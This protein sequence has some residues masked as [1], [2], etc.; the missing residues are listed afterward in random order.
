MIRTGSHYRLAGGP[1][2]EGRVWCH[3]LRYQADSWQPREAGGAG[4]VGSG[5]MCPSALPRMRYSTNSR[6]PL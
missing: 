1:P 5:P 3:E 2:R 6:A 4:G